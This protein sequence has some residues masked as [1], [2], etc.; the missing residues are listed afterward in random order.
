MTLRGETIMEK[1]MAAI[2]EDEPKALAYLH[3]QLSF[4]LQTEQRII[5]FDCYQNGQALIAAVRAGKNY[6]LLFLDIDMPEINGIEV[7]RKI[8]RIHNFPDTALVIFISNREELVFQT[9]EVHPFRFIRKN[10]F[11]E[12]LPALAAAICRELDRKKGVTLSIEEQHS[13]MVYSVNINDIMYVEVMGK[14]CHIITAAK[15]LK[16]RYQLS[17]L[18]DML[19]GYGFLQPHRSY[20]VNCR[21]IFSIENNEILLD[22][23]TAIPV[24]RNRVR[25][26]KQKFLEFT[27]GF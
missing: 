4:Q 1:L 5:D 26:V 24:S 13:N 14:Y 7:C 21:Y 17:A 3:Q 18:S 6:Q 25:Q 16:I 11:R 9:F 23:Q 12:E 10:H 22:D 8:R 15:K 27:R 2:C 19:A 20:L